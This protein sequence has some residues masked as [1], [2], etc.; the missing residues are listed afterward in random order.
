M[1][2]KYLALAT[3]AL[4]LLATP[5]LANTFRWATAAGV[6][7]MDPHASGDTT[8]RNIMINVYE[9]LVRLTADSKLEGELAVSWE[10][11]E[12]T[13]WRFKLRPSVTFHDGSP[14]TADD[15]VFS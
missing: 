6:A 13:V 15:V 7:T 14:F 11:I 2:R 9:G 1:K 12:P 4:M 10:A 5:A 3:A 8:T